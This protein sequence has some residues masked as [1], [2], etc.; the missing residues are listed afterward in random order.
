MGKKSA[1]DI[2]FEKEREKYRK[3][4]RE[5]ER[6]N[7]DYQAALIQK[8]NELNALRQQLMQKEDWINRLLEYTELSE[9]D[10]KTLLE[11]EKTK[12]NVLKTFGEL[13]GIMNRVYRGF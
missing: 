1:K 11:K 3:K 12:A 8:E 6:M 10:M 2:A 7:L 13:G 4:I 5:L 9:E